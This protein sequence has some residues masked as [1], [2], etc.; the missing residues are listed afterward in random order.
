M[1]K[2][3]IIFIS[4]L[5]TFCLSSCS[6]SNNES[7]EDAVTNAFNALK[8]FDKE[9]IS[10]YMDYNSITFTDED[11]E[12][13]DKNNKMFL[14]N[15]SFKILSSQQTQNGVRVDVEITNTNLQKVFTDYISKYIADQFSIT[16]G[17]TTESTEDPQVKADRMLAEIYESEK[18]NTVTTNVTLS[19]EKK[20]GNWNIIVDEPLRAALFGNLGSA[21]DN[22]GG[23][24]EQTEA[25]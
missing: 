20:D 1:L 7:A 23:E 4:I 8:T 14:S 17:E 5:I 22:I 13:A 16:V 24:P 12:G 15:L 10:K 25:Q 9:T 2:K 6:T 19:L 18:D 21:L 11:G 3:Y